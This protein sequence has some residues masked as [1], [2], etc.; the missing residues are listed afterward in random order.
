M[1]EFSHIAAEAARQFGAARSSELPQHSHFHAGFWRRERRVAS[2]GRRW[3]R[4]AFDG[5]GATWAAL[6]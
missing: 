5:G 1:E 4:G 2:L 3:S 6:T